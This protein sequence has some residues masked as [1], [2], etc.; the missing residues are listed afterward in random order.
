M[1]A[2]HG[3]GLRVVTWNLEWAPRSRRAR[4]RERL[5]ALAPDLLC[6]TEAD[7]DVLPA[8]GHAADCE[9]DAGYGVR[10][11]RRKVI[12]WSRWPLDEIDRIGSLELPPGRFVAA[13]CRT[14]A[15]P[16]RVL[17]VCIPWSHAHVRSGRRDRV[18]WQDH[19]SYLDALG[20]LIVRQDESL[21]LVLLGDFNQRIPR[22]RAPARV[23]KALERALGSL[24]VATA[25]TVPGIDRQVIDHLAHSR[26][27]LVRDIEGIDRRDLNGRLLSDHDGVMATIGI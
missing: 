22:T 7:R 8:G 23:A 4:I 21:P 20:P 13:T 17:G 26:S 25:G 3:D 14:P 24:A 11:G 10:G 1:S 5:A 12:L 6:A 16:I 18:A 27:L 15:G 19:L 9:P 2:P